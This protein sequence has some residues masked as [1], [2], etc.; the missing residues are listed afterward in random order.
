MSNSRNENYDSEAD[1]QTEPLTEH[2]G[3]NK[4]ALLPPEDKYNMIYVIFFLYGVGILLPFN[5][6]TTAFDF[7]IAQVSSSTL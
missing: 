7:F 1:F 5:A 2:N 6:V 4:K 3:T